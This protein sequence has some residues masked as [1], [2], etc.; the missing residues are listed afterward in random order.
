MSDKGLL[1]TRPVYD[2]TKPIKNIEIHPSYIRMLESAFLYFV[3]EV[4]EN[5][6][7]IKE[8]F[9]KF[10]K[11]YKAIHSDKGEQVALNPV[12]AHMWTIY[13]MMQLL[14]YKA[15]EQGLE[16]IEETNVT[17]EE[18]SNWVKEISK[19]DKSKA[20]EMLIEINNKLGFKEE[21]S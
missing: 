10:D 5:P 8:I 18:V 14:R 1:S 4:L 2:Q 16:K 17:Q 21:S 19:G 20:Q 11:T 12:E 15:K 6:A 13:S 7:E 3:T 9:K